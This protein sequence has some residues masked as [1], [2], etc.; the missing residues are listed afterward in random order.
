MHVYIYAYIH[1]HI[2]IYI[3]TY[4]LIFIHIYLFP[5]LR[6][7]DGQHRAAAGEFKAQKDVYVVRR[8]LHILPGHRS[9]DVDWIREQYQPVRKN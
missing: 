7:S 2:H 5:Q 6:D 1:T 9:H 8:K 3:H 4:I